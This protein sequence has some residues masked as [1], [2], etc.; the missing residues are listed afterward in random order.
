MRGDC[1]GSMQDVLVVAWVGVWLC[2]VELGGNL[3]V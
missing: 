1:F 2:G 3:G